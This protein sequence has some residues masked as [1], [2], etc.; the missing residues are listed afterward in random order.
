MKK[1]ILITFLTIALLNLSS[2][3]SQSLTFSSGFLSSDFKSE[4]YLFNE[5]NAP[6]FGFWSTVGFKAP[7]WRWVK[8]ESNVTY[9]Q[10]KPLEVFPFCTP[11]GYFVFIGYPTSKQSKEYRP[12]F[13]IF[14]DFKYLHLELIPTVEFGNRLKIAFG[15]GGFYGV[16]L[17]SAEVKRDKYDFPLEESTFHAPW[18]AYGEILYHKLDYGILPK[19]GVS[20]KLNEHLSLGLVGKAYFSKIRLND[21]H[22]FPVL[23]LNQRW[24]AYLCGVEANYFL[25]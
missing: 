12:E 17:N 16:L 24:V 23:P 19:I 21:T 9:Q 2:A 6:K 10:R 14:P 3:Q 1:F 18:N 11:G 20:F 4:I 13:P 15:A 22:V 8:V 25:R 7:I 5:Q